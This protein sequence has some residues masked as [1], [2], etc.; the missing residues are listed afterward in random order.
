MSIDTSGTPGKLL[1]PCCE[2]ELADDD[3]VYFNGNGDIVG[4]ESCI[5]VSL[6]GYSVDELQAIAQACA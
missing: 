4:C 3:K 5:I 6:A 2:E 1:C